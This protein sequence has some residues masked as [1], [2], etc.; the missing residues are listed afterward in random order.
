MILTRESSSQFFLRLTEMWIQ[1]HPTF[2][3]DGILQL[4]YHD[5]KMGMQKPRDKIYHVQTVTSAPTNAPSE[6]PR[7]RILHKGMHKCIGEHDTCPPEQLCAYS[8]CRSAISIGDVNT[9]MSSLFST[10]SP[11]QQQAGDLCCKGQQE[12][13]CGQNSPLPRDLW[14]WPTRHGIPRN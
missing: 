11:E 14:Q 3:E 4:P 10:E 6:G 13:T 1:Y 2:N 9:A 7:R 12:Y 5:I 8:L